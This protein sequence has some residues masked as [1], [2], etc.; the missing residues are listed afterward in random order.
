MQLNAANYFKQI[1]GVRNIKNCLFSRSTYAL[2][3][4]AA[5]LSHRV[6]EYVLHTAKI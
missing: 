6:A 1:T 2:L 5:I 3:L 4:I